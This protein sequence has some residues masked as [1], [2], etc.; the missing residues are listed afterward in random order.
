MVQIIEGDI[1]EFE[2]NVYD[3]DDDLD[4]SGGIEADRDEQLRVTYLWSINDELDTTAGN[5]S[6]YVFSSALSG[7]YSSEFSPYFISLSLNKTF[8][9]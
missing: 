8:F 7:A 2:V 1:Q 4:D 5:E 9:N 6:L 3:P